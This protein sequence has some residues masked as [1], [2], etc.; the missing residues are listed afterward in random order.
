MDNLYEDEYN[1]SSQNIV[2]SNSTNL[3]P[4]LDEIF[5]FIDSGR[6]AGS[7]LVHCD[8]SKPGLSR[9]TAICIA[10]LMYK[11]KKG[12]NEAFNEVNLIIYYFSA[13]IIVIMNISEKRVFIGIFFRNLG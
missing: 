5:D 13:Q 10:Y 11:E 2:D 1:Y 3:K 8:G 6:H 9:S 4:Y 12:F 7:C